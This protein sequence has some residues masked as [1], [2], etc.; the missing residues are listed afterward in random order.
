MTADMWSVDDI[1]SLSESDQ[2]EAPHLVSL[3]PL[4][5][6]CYE[7]DADTPM[8]QCEHIK[9]DNESSFS[10][11]LMYGYQGLGRFAPKQLSQWIQRKPSAHSFK[12]L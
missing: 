11:F 8:H 10:W 1:Q 6:V 12:T 3:T 2:E 5:N 7:K 9:P 4:E